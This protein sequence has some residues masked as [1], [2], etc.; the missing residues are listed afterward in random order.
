MAVTRGAWSCYTAA[1]TIRYSCRSQFG[2]LVE[3]DVP[4]AP[5]NFTVP[6]RKFWSRAIRKGRCRLIFVRIRL[7]GDIRIS[8]RGITLRHPP[9]RDS[10]GTL[11]IFFCRSA[12][13]PSCCRFHGASFARV[14]TGSWSRSRAAWPS[15]QRA[16]FLGAT[17]PI[18]VDPPFYNLNRWALG[19]FVKACAAPSSVTHRCRSLQN[20]PGLQSGQH[21]TTARPKAGASTRAT[22]YRDRGQGRRPQR[23][24]WPAGRV[25]R[26]LFRKS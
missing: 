21:R 17:S 18:H 5:G 23:G 3:I 22:S 13:R 8:K 6:H 26:D 15:P 2:D 4:C 16:R 25:P 1:P 19:T 14:I 9:E 10:R 7:T 11:P 20:R 24:N 12:F